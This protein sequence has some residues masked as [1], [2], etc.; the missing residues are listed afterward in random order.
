[1]F[2]RKLNGLTMLELVVALLVLGFLVL[3]TYA[4]QKK[5]LHF[6]TVAMV[7]AHLLDISNRQ[8]EYL[9]QHKV[10]AKDLKQLGM[11]KSKIL[12]S[13]YKVVI[14]DVDNTASSMGYMVKAIPIT[15]SGDTFTL[16]HLGQ[17]SENWG[18]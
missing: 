17:T 4:N 11:V 18:R 10:Y 12:A 14:A 15:E 3:V 7:K 16:N 1:M 6:N 13:H 8:N 9:L 2:K 5:Q